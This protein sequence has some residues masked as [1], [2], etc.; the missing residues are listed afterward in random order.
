MKLVGVKPRP[1]EVIEVTLLRS[2]GTPRARGLAGVVVVLELGG[3][4]LS[5][6]GLRLM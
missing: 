1:L 4:G 5:S 2:P 6:T 3:L